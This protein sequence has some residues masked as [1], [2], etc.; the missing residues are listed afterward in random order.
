MRALFA[1]GLLAATACGGYAH[2]SN[3]QGRF[4]VQSGNTVPTCADAVGKGDAC[5]EDD[6]QVNGT[7]SGGMI[8]MIAGGSSYTARIGRAHV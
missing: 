6:L 7:L 3:V 4:V 8:K 5:V 2:D 1:L